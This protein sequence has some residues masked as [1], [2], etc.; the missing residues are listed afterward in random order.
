MLFFRCDGCG[1]EF[2]SR[3]SFPDTLDLMLRQGWRVKKNGRTIIDFCPVC[4]A[5]E[6]KKEEESVLSLIRRIAD[7][8]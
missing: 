6:K 3:W 2:E 4:A 8:R 5:V 7:D 1:R